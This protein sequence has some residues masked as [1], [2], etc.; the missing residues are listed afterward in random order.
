MA[1]TF[2]RILVMGFSSLTHTYRISEGHSGAWPDHRDGIMPKD[3]VLPAGSESYTRVATLA[4][5]DSVKE[6]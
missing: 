3:V 4:L 6:E 5:R 2:V 1:D